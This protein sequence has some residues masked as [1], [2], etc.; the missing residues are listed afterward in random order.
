MMEMERKDGVL[1]LTNAEDKRIGKIYMRKGQ[2]VQASID[3]DDETDHKQCVYRM[4]GWQKGKFSFAGMAIDLEDK[5][6]S[7][8][9]GLLMEGA[10]LIDES[11]R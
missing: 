11:N 5:V 10:R 8:T 6:Q 2:V 1:A 3:G 9:T 4:L 7:T